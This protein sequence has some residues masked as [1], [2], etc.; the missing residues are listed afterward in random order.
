MKKK[1]FLVAAVLGAALIGCDRGG[2]AGEPRE[3]VLEG[4][5]NYR[6]GEFSLAIRDFETVEKDPG[7]NPEV[8]LQALYGLATTW[9]LRRPDEDV[10]K[11]TPYYKQVINLA[12]QSDWAAWSLLALARMK[13]LVPVG[14]EPDVPKLYQAY[15]GVIDKFPKHTAGEE[16]LVFQQSLLVSTFKPEDAQKALAILDKFVTTHPQSY[17]LSSAYGLMSYCH[18]TLGEPEKKL[19]DLIRQLETQKVDPTNPFFEN[20]GAYWA[21]ATVAEFEAG[22]FETARKYYQKLLTEYPVDSRIFA[23]KQALKRM[24]GVEA[25]FRGTTTRK[26]AAS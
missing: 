1:P 6:M 26:G 16:A 23:T 21:I 18:D 3:K 13:H 20:A 12:P 19:H 9:N 24:D 25:K 22:D 8:R 10:K 7:A 17:F 14:T 5:T 2:P 4:W 15:Q 11:A